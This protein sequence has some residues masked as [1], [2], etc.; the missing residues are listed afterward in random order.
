MDRHLEIV[1]GTIAPA[2]IRLASRT[3]RKSGINGAEMKW[4]VRRTAEME[5]WGIGLKLMES[6]PIGYKSRIFPSWG[7]F[8]RGLMRLNN[9]LCWININH[10]EFE[11]EDP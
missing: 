2:G 3:V 4:G 9:V 11:S 6:Y 5:N 10:M 7:M 1:F 8:S